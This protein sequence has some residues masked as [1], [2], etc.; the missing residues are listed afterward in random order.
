M[1]CNGRNRAEVIVRTE[2]A[3]PDGD[4]LR[5]DELFQF[6]GAW[7]YKGPQTEPAL[8]KEPLEFKYVKPGDSEGRTM[9]NNSN[10]HFVLKV[11]R[12]ASPK[13]KGYLSNASRRRHF[14]RYVLY[15]TIGYCKQPP[16]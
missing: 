12:Q 2:S 4:T 13:A 10:M 9:D 14:S 16:G 7:E 1:P 8:H 3:T 11:W 6:V 5:N 15:G